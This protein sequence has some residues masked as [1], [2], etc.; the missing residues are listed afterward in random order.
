VVGDAHIEIGVVSQGV[1]RYAHMAIHPYPSTLVQ[2]W[3]LRDGTPVLIRPLKPE[4]AELEQTFVRGLSSET[5]YFRFM[6][7]LRELPPSLLAKLTQI[8]YDRELAL[9]ATIERE[10]TLVEIGVCRY[11]TNA[12]GESCEFA[13]VVAD[14]FQHSGVGRKLMETLIGCA[15]EGGLKTMKGVFLSDNERM[16]RFVRNIGFIISPDPETPTIKHGTLALQA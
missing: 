14:D 13:I 3:R 7:A 15:R 4:D 10:G 9:I 16:L 11:S 8:D 5:K 6:S 2:S 1:G 12:D